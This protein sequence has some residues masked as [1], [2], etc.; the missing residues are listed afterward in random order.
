MSLYP[1]AVTELGNFA[2]ER[3]LSAAVRVVL[4]WSMCPI[5]P[6]FT[7]GLVRLNSPLAMSRT[8]KQ[9]SSNH[10]PTTRGKPLV[11]REQSLAISGHWGLTPGPPPYQGGALPLSYASDEPRL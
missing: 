10:P 11:L 1:F 6:T 4:P 5:V 3:A 9:L 8:S 2:A 7:W